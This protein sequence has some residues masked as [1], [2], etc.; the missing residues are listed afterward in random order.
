VL[1]SRRQ[2]QLLAREELAASLVLGWIDLTLSTD[3]PVVQDL[4]ANATSAANRLKLIGERVGLFAHSKSAEFFSM[5]S[6]LS[7]FLR[8]IESNVIT[9]PSSVQVLYTTGTE[10][11]DASRRVITEWAAATGK[12]LKTRAKPVETSRRPL[13]LVR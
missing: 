8:A 2:S 4:K 6:E 10:L 5:A 11:G 1:R 13:A 9:G 7:L 3:T 12:D